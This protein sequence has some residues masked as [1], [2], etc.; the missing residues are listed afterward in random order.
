MLIWS[1]TRGCRQVWARLKAAATVTLIA[2][3]IV[4]GSELAAGR[5]PGRDFQINAGMANAS[6]AVPVGTNLFAAASDEDN[7]LRLYRTS[8]DGRPVAEFDMSPFLGLWGRSQ[9][10]DLEGAALLGDRAYWM[11]SLS[12]SKDG[13]V[14]PNRHRLFATQVVETNGTFR[15]V[16]VGRPCTTLLDELAAAPS[17]AQFRLREASAR[18][19]DEEGGLNIEGLAATPDG[20]LLL[21]FRNPIPEGRALLIPLLN[22]EDV[23]NGHPASF[24]KPAQLDLGG[25]GIRDLVW[26]G[27]EYFILAG[28]AGSGGHERLFRW[29]GD[30]S[31]PEQIE[32]SRLRH[33]NPEA[34][35]VFGEPSKPR[36]LVLS[37]DGNKQ[38]SIPPFNGS[39]SMRRF[40]SFWITP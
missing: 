3:T 24:G 21:G 14:R 5:P 18:A 38:D 13:R 35:A 20:G 7:R 17:L 23:I 26:S 37:D 27:R 11:G 19:A 22:P 6:A 1:T 10:V 4:L 16:P 31:P 28:R 12:R 8:G 15:L 40:R 2:S 33:F 32:H 34:L 9:E 39:Q 29:K 30:D 25:L 36:L